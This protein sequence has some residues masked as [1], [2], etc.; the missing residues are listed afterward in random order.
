MEFTF[1][2]CDWCSQQVQSPDEEYPGLCGQCVKH[3]NAKL[4]LLEP[5]EE[6]TPEELKALCR[7][8][9]DEESQAIMDE[10]IR[11]QCEQIQAGW[12]ENM[13]ESRRVIKKK[14]KPLLK[15]FASLDKARFLSLPAS[16]LPKT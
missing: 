14:R 7:M 6:L 4:E 11:R 12:S 9:Y 15:M 10:F 3:A 2:R 8:D 5:G 1:T 13:E 16:S